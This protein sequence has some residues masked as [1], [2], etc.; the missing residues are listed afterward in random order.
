M[1]LPTFIYHYIC[2]HLQ[3]YID[4]GHNVTVF[5][6]GNKTKITW[7]ITL[8]MKIKLQNDGDVK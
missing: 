7:K 6:C 3:R 2:E 8:L 4:Y 5:E 1:K